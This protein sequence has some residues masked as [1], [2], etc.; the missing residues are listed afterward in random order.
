M[1][2]MKLSRFNKP[3]I[4]KPIGRALLGQFFSRFEP[5]LTAC[6]LAL[7][8]PE[9]GDNDYYTALA[10]LLLNPERLPDSLNEALFDIES[11]AQP[12]A[13]AQLEASS[14]W[15][16]LQPLLKPDAAREELVLQTW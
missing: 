11:V 16:E 3:E 9:I 15:R 13:F 14:R 4:L 12:K 10:W 6:G 1:Q 7:P 8:P 2:T 5:D